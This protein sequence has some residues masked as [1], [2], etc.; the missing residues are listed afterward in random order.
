LDAYPA[1]GDGD[2]QE[3]EWRERKKKK[4]EEEREEEEEKGRIEKERAAVGRAASNQLA[5][6]VRGAAEWG[7]VIPSASRFE[8]KEHYQTIM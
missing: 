2:T 8:K 7:Q 6:A 3:E 1:P 5:K 4:R